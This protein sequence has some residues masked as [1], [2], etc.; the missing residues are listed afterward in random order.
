MTN[1]ET[2]D[3][4]GTNEAPT[5][6]SDETVEIPRSAVEGIVEFAS[7]EL[8]SMVDFAIALGAIKTFTSPSEIAS[9]NETTVQLPRKTVDTFESYLSECDTDEPD[10]SLLYDEDFWEQ[11]DEATATARQALAE[12]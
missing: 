2:P 12:Q 11:F 1:S 5:T 3:G 8:D 4:T 10:V 9:A 6:T 7:M